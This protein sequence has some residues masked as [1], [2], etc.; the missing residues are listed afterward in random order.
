M[1]ICI[2]TQLSLL[3]LTLLTILVVNE[4]TNGT[5]VVRRHS[6]INDT[7]SSCIEEINDIM[8]AFDTVKKDLETLRRN[9][10]KSIKS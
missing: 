4:K 5:V 7:D 2:L 1:K 8:T 9:M 10:D 6:T 3:Y